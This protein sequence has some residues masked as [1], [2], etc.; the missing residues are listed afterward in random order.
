MNSEIA[1]WDDRFAGE[2]FLFGTDPNAFL[3]RSV[4]R[5]APHSRVLAVADGEGRNGVWLAQHGHAV[6]S[7]E[8]SPT[9]V[10]RAE[11]LATSRGVPLVAS[12]DE[13]VPGSLLAEVGDVLDHGWPR[14]AYDGVVAI[15]IQFAKPGAERET[16]FAA[17]VE[18]LAPGGVL[19]LEGYTSKQ[20]EYGTGGP[21]S[22]AHL[23]DESFLRMM[24]SHLT[25]ESL[26]AY[27]AELQ[28]GP[29]HSGLS[30]VIDVVA[31]RSI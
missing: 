6:H 12:L 24:M 20:L 19:L 22:L 11:Q 30:A 13:L 5:L 21:K 29:G 25:I 23:Y 28:E 17:M 9:A 16:L 14:E 1:S 8:G 4:D 27:E 2:G 26:I 10:A 7:I 31:S 3:A 18:A 15:F